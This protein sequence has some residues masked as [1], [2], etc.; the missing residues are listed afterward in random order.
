MTIILTT[1]YLEEAEEMCDEIAI[2]NHGQVI[3]QDSTVALVGRLD[4][5]TLVIQPEGTAPAAIPLP[6]GVTL[7]RRADGALAFSY[8]RGQVSADRVLDAVRA[9][10]VT[11]ADVTSEQADLQ[12]VFLSLTGSS[13]PDAA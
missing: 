2:V 3:A 5:K 9:G 6:D 10:G 8:R 12:D 4:A 1:H 7:E 13:A 11:I